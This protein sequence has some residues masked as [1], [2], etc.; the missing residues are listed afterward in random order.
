ML[1]SVGHGSGVSC[2]LG[3]PGS[4]LAGRCLSGGAQLN[5]VASCRGS[6]K[7]AF[8]AGVGQVVPGF[9]DLPFNPRAAFEVPCPK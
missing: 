8:K 3:P 7:D 9:Q 5:D 4:P 1:A 6:P 2:H